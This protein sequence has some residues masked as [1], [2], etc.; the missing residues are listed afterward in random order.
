MFF[1]FYGTAVDKKYVFLQ[2]LIC[3]FKYAMLFFNKM[4]FLERSKSAQWGS[5]WLKRV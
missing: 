1:L 4:K 2:K 5:L 3:K